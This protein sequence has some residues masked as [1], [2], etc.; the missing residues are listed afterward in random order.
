MKLR[1]ATRHTAF[2]T[3]LASAL[4]LGATSTGAIAQV[5]PANGSY[6]Y[7]GYNN[8][9]SANER[10]IAG[11]VTSFGGYAMQLARANGG[12][13]RGRGNRENDGDD[14]RNNGNNGHWNNGNGRYNNN[15]NCGYS[16]NRGQGEDD[17]GGR[18]GGNRAGNCYGNTAYGARNASIRLHPG[19]VINPTGATIQPG[20]R[21]RVTGHPNGD[22]SFEA[23]RIDLVANSYYNRTY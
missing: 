12:A 4:A 14:N 3:I 9:Y 6:G 18:D 20:M 19:T 13:N 1:T 8:G 16:Y 21:V 23:D 11:T 10:T 5:Y 2:A 22:G 7:N 15:G 17:N